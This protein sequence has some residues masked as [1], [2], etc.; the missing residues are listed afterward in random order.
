MVVIGPRACTNTQNMVLSPAPARLF[1]CVVPCAHGASC[2]TAF[3]QVWMCSCA[4]HVWPT[5]PSDKVPKGFGKL[6]NN[7]LHLILPC[8]NNK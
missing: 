4:T 2:S 1:L 6:R 7:L 8:P 3:Q 5:L